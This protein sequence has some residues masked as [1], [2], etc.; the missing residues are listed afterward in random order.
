MLRLVVF[1]AAVFAGT[2]LFALSAEQLL[3][4]HFDPTRINPEAAGEPRLREIEREGLVLWVADPAPGRPTILYFHGNAGNLANRIA[5]FSAFLDR[6]LGVIAMAY[7]GSSGSV[8][9]QNSQTIQEFAEVL[10]LQVPALVT[11]G[12]IILY[13]ESLGT[14]VALQLA[15]SDAV[16]ESP[17]VAIVLEAPYTSILDLGRQIYPRLGP[18]LHWLGDP[19][20]SREWITMQDTPLLVLHGTEDRIIPTQMGRD[21]FRLSPATDK[22]LHLVAGAGHNNVW[23]V[24]AQEV[25]YRFLQRF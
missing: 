5:R 22:I 16:G 21:I 12:P 13:G 25:L 23:Q 6:G 1:L 3:L 15:A 20:V 18:Y 7:P 10:Y 4:F 9:K 14:G 11:P 19:W 24:S 17:P 8:G 2:T